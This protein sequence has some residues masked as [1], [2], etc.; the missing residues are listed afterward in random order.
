MGA[1]R[2]IGHQVTLEEKDNNSDGA[3]PNEFKT[4]ATLKY[5]PS[6]ERAAD[7][8]VRSLSNPYSAIKQ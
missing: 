1:T 5:E 8:L 4:L 3:G 2:T 7:S 6:W